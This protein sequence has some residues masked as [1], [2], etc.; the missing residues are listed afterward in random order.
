MKVRKSNII[1]ILVF[2]F[3]MMPVFAQKGFNFKRKIL[4]VKTEWQQLFLPIEMYKNCKP[5]FSDIRIQAYTNLGDTLI[6]PYIL[7]EVN[8]IQK[9]QKVSFKIINESYRNDWYYFTLVCP[10][11]VLVN[12]LELNFED[13]NF[14]WH[15]NLD[16]AEKLGDWMTILDDVRILS[17]KNQESSYVF[18]KLKFSD[19]KF[20][21][22]RVSIHGTTKPKLKSVLLSY[23]ENIP[24]SSISYHVKNFNSKN[25]LAKKETVV[26]FEL[27]E[28]LP[29]KS[30]QLFA[31]T[32]TD[33]FRNTLL[34]YAKDSV[35]SDSKW[36]YIYSPV[37]QSYISSD[38]YDP[39]KFSEIQAKKFRLRIFNNDNEPI[40]L[41]SVQVFGPKHK[42]IIRLN[43]FAA[44]YYLFYGNKMV[45]APVYDL[46]NFKNK[47]PT[48][49]EN[50]NLGPEMKGD[51]VHE[52]ADVPIVQKKSWLWL[53]LIAMVL[54]LSYFS[55]KML[56]QDKR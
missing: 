48:E 9:Q 44:N 20:P 3:G 41:E 43:N 22:Y 51:I 26:D 2:L 47:I 19:S 29:V 55:I 31:K 10:T 23:F 50:L 53:V 12:N 14:D 42:L 5:D 21:Y 33:Y 52:E 25:D 30:I 39:I 16:A 28:V 37:L 38:D 1:F 7:E 11:D 27:D 17:F 56:K 45:Q 13:E 32:H 35:L 4:G 46:I 24:E 8:S 49:L 36:S 15:V 34:E 40:K 18:S 6:V 54:L